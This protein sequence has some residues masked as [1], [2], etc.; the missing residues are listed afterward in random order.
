MNQA[1]LSIVLPILNESAQLSDLLTDLQRQRQV[2]FKVLFV[3]GGS[4]DGSPEW[5]LNNLEKTGL[6]AAVMTAPRGRGRQMNLGAQQADT[7]WILFLHAD[8]RFEDPLSLRKGLDTLQ[9]TGSQKLAGHYALKFRRAEQSPSVGYYY[10]E[11]KARLGRPE[12]IHGDQGFLLRCDFFQQLGGF[13]EDLM[14]ME[15]TDFAE[16]LRNAGQWKLLPAEI[17]TSARRFET[18]GLWQRQLLGA[19]IMCFRSIGWQQFFVAAP[20]LY[21]QQAETDRLQIRP[22][23]HLIRSLMF[24]MGR[25][26]AWRIWWLSGCY[27]QRHAWQ[28]TFALDARGAFRQGVP[29]GQGQM[30]LTRLFEPLYDLLTSHLPGRIAATILLRLW[31][32]LTDIWLKWKERAA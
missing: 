18:E 1:E 21:R 6:Q 2:D 29:V 22:F 8:S 28:L 3:D 25:R 27:V 5:L 16:R 10:Y 24:R 14:V 9:Q 13:R 7:D 30:A 4:A 19:L 23:F 17:S 11:W 20:E 32:E 15:D 31:F 12:T 26:P